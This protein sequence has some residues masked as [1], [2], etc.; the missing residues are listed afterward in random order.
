[1]RWLRVDFLELFNDKL[2]FLDISEGVNL[3]ERWNTIKEESGEVKLEAASLGLSF[4]VLLHELETI[5][6]NIIGCVKYFSD[7]WQ[8]NEVDLILVWM[9]LKHMDRGLHGSLH[10]RSKYD[11]PVH[12]IDNLIM[13]L[14]LLDT[15][16]MQLWI[17]KVLAIHDSFEFG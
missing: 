8:N 9:I 15:N 6:S 5:H 13:R 4:S 1:M 16:S 14:T 2:L 17:S 3:P 7:H 10:W 12:T 11:F